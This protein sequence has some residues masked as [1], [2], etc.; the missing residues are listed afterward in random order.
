MFGSFLRNWLALVI[1]EALL[2]L[3]GDELHDVGAGTLDEV[4]VYF[5]DLHRLSLV[6]LFHLLFGKILFELIVLN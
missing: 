2:D 5:D 4:G 6:D 1:F 3:T